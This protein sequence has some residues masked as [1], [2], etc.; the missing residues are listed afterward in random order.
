MSNQLLI[1]CC[2][3][4]AGVLDMIGDFLDAM[5]KRTGW[6]FT[7]IGG[8]P[9]PALDGRIRT[10]SVHKG[11]DLYGLT[12]SKALPKYR[13]TIIQPYSKFLHS[14]YRKY[15][16]FSLNLKLTINGVSGIHSQ[17]IQIKT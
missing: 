10:V 8:G 3:A 16:V 7:V 14:V 9:D 6:S 17:V 13:E 15:S 12:F 2:S 1:F 5:T 4:Q 11:L